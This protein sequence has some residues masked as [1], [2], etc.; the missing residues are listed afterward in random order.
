MTREDVIEKTALE[1]CRNLCE[2]LECKEECD[3]H[4][5]EGILSITRPCLLMIKTAKAIL[6][7]CYDCKDCG[8]SGRG[9]QIAHF[10]YESCP[11]CKGTGKGEKVLAIVEPD[12]S[13]PE[14]TYP[15]RGDEF[16]GCVDM[17]AARKA[18]DEAQQDMIREG[19]VKTTTPKDGVVWKKVKV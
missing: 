9:K 14:N 7:L 18:Y 4:I 1:A 17:K 16:G 8:G 12:Q 19:W 6:N 13:L 2:F 5:K 15:S 3:N 10:E 11:F